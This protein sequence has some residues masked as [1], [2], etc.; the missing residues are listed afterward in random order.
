MD[1]FDL[2]DIYEELAKTLPGMEAWAPDPLLEQLKSRSWWRRQ[3][4]L[5]SDDVKLH[6]I[7]LGIKDKDARVAREAASSPLL[8]PDMLRVVMQHEDETVRRK[9]LQNPRIPSEFIDMALANPEL[10][11]EDMFNL[12]QNPALLHPHL[13]TLRQRLAERGEE[14]YN[15]MGDRTLE[16][17]LAHPNFD[18]NIANKMALEASEAR[19]QKMLER[20]ATNPNLT[21]QTISAIIGAG[22]T[23][24]EYRLGAGHIAKLIDHPNF[25]NDHTLQVM[26]GPPDLPDGIRSTAIA[27][28]K[29]DARHLEWIFNPPNEE[30]ADRRN[31]LSRYHRDR[32]SLSSLTPDL[33]ERGVSNPHLASSLRMILMRAAGPEQLERFAQPDHP[34]S[35]EALH[36]LTNERQ[37]IPEDFK[38]RA[39]S[40]AIR[41]PDYYTA[42]PALESQ[43]ANPQDLDWVIRN[44]LPSEYPRHFNDALDNHLTP[45][46]TFRWA[47]QHQDPDVRERVGMSDSKNAPKDMFQALLRD[48]E[49]AVRS[50]VAKR[51]ADLLDDQDL[52]F[53]LQSDLFDPDTQRSMLRDL[54]RENVSPDLFRTAAKNPELIHKVAEHMRL[55]PQVAHEILDNPTTKDEIR[56]LIYN[57]ETVPLR[58]EDIDRMLTGND[59]YHH[60]VA[61]GHASTTQRQLKSFLDRTDVGNTERKKAQDALVDLDP[62]SGYEK[63]HVRHGTAKLRK[64][65]DLILQSGADD[66][67]PNKLGNLPGG[68]DWNQMRLPN[69]NISA[70]KIQA[71]IDAMPATAFNTSHH[72]AGWSGL[73][74]HSDERQKVFQ[75]NLT[76][77]MMQKL[78]DMGLTKYWEK[79]RD[80]YLRS[81]PVNKHT[82]GWV[83]YTGEPD[84][85]FFIDEVQSDF[86]KSP[87]ARRI[88]NVK[89]R[90]KDEEDLGLV[91]RKI[92]EA[93]DDVVEEYGPE[94]QHKDFLNIVFGDKHPHEVLHEAFAQH[95]R[96]Y[97]YAGTKI[98]VHTAKS[99]APLSGWDADEPVPV[100]A[101]IAYE[102][103]PKKMGMEPG[104]YNRG[105]MPT[106][107][108]NDL[109][110]NAV[111]QDELH[112]YENL[113]EL[114][115]KLILAKIEKRN[116]EE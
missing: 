97:G 55:P 106:M 33:I 109:Q 3:Q 23:S 50:V 57:N 8:T 48:P 90:H 107:S 61:I 12:T 67:K 113:K 92:K 64:I 17:I 65:R 25:T 51:K 69:G 18:A 60:R 20:L 42:K 36:L 58:P 39:M 32:L 1:D 9:A 100:H 102:D 53:V 16:A 76:T 21:P 84:K 85:G 43:L 77:Q 66:M 73:Q 29:I 41:N 94:Q 46:E 95:L 10:S 45:P 82:V 68:V 62:D 59:A 105:T 96:D 79:I 6:H 91:E 88:A 26:T 54:T 87:H 75:L 99:K 93:Y 98:A 19:D 56:N 30:E 110:G 115:K 70:K 24:N 35:K 31:A 111:W 38:R 80:P 83:R 27:S 5:Q 108:N 37:D 89:R 63:T 28:G 49:H 116:G 2:S 104:T 114:I 86:A 14:R 44:M 11:E 7:L 47:A 52:L 13:D 78:K 4:A 22:P 71:Y 15:Y 81:H 103:H 101:K 74:T 72:A 112:K 40:L 34:R